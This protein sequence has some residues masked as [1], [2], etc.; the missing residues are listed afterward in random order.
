MNQAYSPPH[1]Y[2]THTC[3]ELRA[4][5]ENQLVRLSGWVHRKRHH[6]KV[7]FIDLRD[8]YGITQCVVSSDH[9]LFSLLSQASLESV[10]TVS[11]K[12]VCRTPDTINPLLPSGTIEIVIQE[13]LVQSAARALPLE[14][15]N[16]NKTF[17]E[18]TRLT[19]RFLDLRRKKIHH[20]IVLRSHII[21]SLRSRMIAQGFLEFQTPVLTASSPEGA[22]DYLVP[23]RIHPGHFYALPQSPQQ[24]KQ[25]LMVGGFD[26]YFQ[27]AP[28]FRDEDARADRSPGEFYQLDFEMAFATQEDVWHAIA[29]V[30][31]GVF[32]EFAPHRSITPLPFP[33]ISYHQAMLS[34]GTDKPDLRNP[35]IIKDITH[36]MPP[37][38]PF[39]KAC[40]KGAVVRTLLAPS[41]GKNPRS[42]FQKLQEWAQENGLPGLGYLVWSKGEFTGPLSKF[43]TDKTRDVLYNLHHPTEED[44]IFFVCA[45]EEKA[46]EAGALLRQKLGEHLSL[47]DETAYAFCWITDFPFYTQDPQGQITFCHNPF[48]MPQ[49]GMEALLSQDPLTIKAYQYDLVCN[50]IELSSGAIRNHLPDVMEKA[51]EIAG[52]PPHILREKFQGLFEAFQ[53]GA[54]PHGGA[55]PGIDRMVML[56][57]EE[58]NI[59]EVIA[60]PLNQRAQDLMMKA[61][62]RVSPSQTQELSLSLGGPL[63][64]PTE[65]SPEKSLENSVAKEKKPCP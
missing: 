21:S 57:A 39:E 16:E 3:G 36:V 15:N 35:L 60:F 1:P 12:V 6:G 38:A 27:I 14:V 49:G 32:K 8:H 26:K 25:L 50:G 56:L 7:L 33:A 37:I 24:F 58:K 42:F 40:Q 9:R 45:P 59:R 34:Y 43:F 53:F 62:S 54:P 28:C 19:Y 44:G 47:I 63:E 10:L 17:P 46:C 65:K 61:P 4:H 51:F 20:N 23:S 30:I 64:K 31:Y 22:R 13:A 48:S 52:Y 55:A 11:G 5:H 29:P 18:E 41:I 2:R